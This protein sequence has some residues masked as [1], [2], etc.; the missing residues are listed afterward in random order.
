M[1]ERRQ[2]SPA[3]RQKTMLVRKR[4]GTREQ[5]LATMN[6]SVQELAARHP[7]RAILCDAPS[8]VV[9]NCTYGDNTATIWLIP[10]LVDLVAFTNSRQ[11]LTDQ[12]VTAVAWMI[13][14]EYGYLK[15]SELMLFF[16]RFKLGRYG[17]FYGSVDPMLITT[18][19]R[20]F[21]GERAEV[22][23]RHEIEQEREQREQYAHQ[24]IT[25]AEYC[26]RNGLPEMSLQQLILHNA[27]DKR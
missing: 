14:Q 13:V 9:I 10:Q 5:F 8:L 1:Q 6:P 21:L 15:C 25:L 22:L 17:H 4:Y 18:A 26:R 16:Y 19:I 24:A 3:L 12:Q 23:H 27:N 2:L 11:L 20:R 7:D